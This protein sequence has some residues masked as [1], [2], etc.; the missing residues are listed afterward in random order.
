MLAT[1]FLQKFFQ[2]F[3]RTKTAENLCKNP[4]RIL[5]KFKPM[6]LLGITPAFPLEISLEVPSKIQPEI[7]QAVLKKYAQSITGRTFE[8]LNE[9]LDNFLKK[10]LKEFEKIPWDFFWKFS[11]NILGLKFLKQL[12]K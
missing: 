10:F 12:L 4:S 11:G 8:F 6:V 2:G 1:K 9:F 3:Y 5:A 7:I